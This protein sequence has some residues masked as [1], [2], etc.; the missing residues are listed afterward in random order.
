MTREAKIGMLTGLGVIVLIGVLLSQY[1]GDGHSALPGLPM[2]TNV[3]TGQPAS[4]PVGETFRQQVMEPTGVPAM[5]ADGTSMQYPAVADASPAS[6]PPAAF[7]AGQSEDAG[8]TM[9]GPV[10]PVT[11]GTVADAPAGDSTPPVITLADSHL[12]SRVTSAE[13]VPVNQVVAAPAPGVTYQVAAGDTLM[14]LSRKFYN[15]IKMADIQR[16]VAANPTILKDEKTPLIQG[17]KLLIPGVT[18]SAAPAGAIAKSAPKAGSGMIIYPPGGSPKAGAGPVEQPG[19][20][21]LDSPK[22]TIYVVRSGDT[23]EKIARKIAPAQPEAMVQKIAAMNHIKDPRGL[24][25]GDRL[26]LPV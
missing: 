16:I 6:V 12:V 3:A 23:L 24:H 19:P 18:P 10:M 5:V 2:T 14:K 17:K 4:L 15:S 9:T 22:N 21:K 8:P 13:G 11:V 1:L 26:K 7:A 20:V 25:E